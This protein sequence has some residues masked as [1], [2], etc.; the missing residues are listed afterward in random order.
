MAS[1]RAAVLLAMV[2][3]LA[4]LPGGAPD[5][6]SA[7]DKAPNVGLVDVD[8]VA[9]NLTDYRGEVLLID[10]MS[11]TCD[12]CKV[13]AQDIKRLQNDDVEDLNIISIDIQPKFDKVS[14]LREY[15][16]SHGYAW[17]FAMDT[18]DGKALQSYGVIEIPVIVI[19]DRDGYVTYS[20]KGL[21]GYDQMKDAAEDALSGEAEAI[22][23]VQIGLLGMAFLA[24]LAS[25]FSPCSFPLLPGY[26]T[27]YFKQ[28]A[29]ARV[30][31]DAG[32]RAR[33][34]GRSAVTGLKLG[35]FA[36]GGIVLVYGILGVVIIGLVLVG[37]GISDKAISYMKPA[38]GII[39]LVMGALTLLDVPLNTGY[40]T[41]P[42][43]RLWESLRPSKGPRKPS[44]GPAG[45]F[46][47]GVAY[48]SA[49]ASCSVPIFI[50][51][52]GIS[53]ST[54]NPMDALMTFVVFLLSM[55]LLMAVMTSV[56]SMG[57]ERVKKGLMRHY[58][59]IKKV[60]GVVFVFAGGYLMW[61]F[62]E[63]EGLI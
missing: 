21:Q 46:L 34:A 5:G 3:L 10:F 35:S 56:L 8:G 61:L 31:G 44:T 38:V 12:P 7:A 29:D 15:A 28:R 33:P 23:L 36:G 6:V 39:L 54:G 11:L 48:G 57:E 52:V 25:F 1:R 20:E 32:D 49:S 2:A 17:R 63:A 9:F 26:I 45:L 40:I 22:D 50:A 13:V 19:I 53:V 58:I 16:T 30:E 55:W 24:G 59:A 43:S 27:Y 41:A 37:V 60:T 62:L 51:L 47:Y 14:D 4:L 18:D 42:F